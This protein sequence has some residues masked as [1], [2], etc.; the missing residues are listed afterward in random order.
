MERD[1]STERVRECA[2]AS[3]PQS[4]PLKKNEATGQFAELQSVKIN[5]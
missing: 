2:V 3:T 5:I 4:H 1:G